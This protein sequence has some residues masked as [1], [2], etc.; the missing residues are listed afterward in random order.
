MDCGLIRPELVMFHF[1]DVDAPARASIEEHLQSCGDCVRA[2]LALKREIET[3]P[4]R[5]EVPSAAARDRLRRAVSAE[6]GARRPARPV[7][8]GTA[9]AAAAATLLLVFAVRVIQPSLHLSGPSPRLHSGAIDTANP[10]D[11]PLPL[12]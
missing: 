5:G 3:A 9:V 12:L 2:F 8:W 7:A 4:E 6:I 11:A 1:G 10:P